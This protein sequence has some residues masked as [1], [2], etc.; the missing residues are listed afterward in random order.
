MTCVDC[1]GP[2]SSPRHK[3]CAACAKIRHVA[4]VARWQANNEER[5]RA[6][7]RDYYRSNKE[8]IA[9]RTKRWRSTNSDRERERKR[10]WHEKDPGLQSAYTRKSKYGISRE[11][12]AAILAAQ[13]GKCAICQASSPGA[14]G[15][16]WHVDHD[17]RF[18]SSDPT[19]HRGLLCKACNIGLGAFRDNIG[20]MED[21][22]DYLT[23]HQ[24]HLARASRA[25]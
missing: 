22:I 20:V 6:W 24:L 9:E 3:V 25:A 5:M 23:A 14:R 2:K 21:A 15:Q 16:G 7:R 13:G 18:A 8:R 11:R 4:Q 17:H 10:R 1:G 19:G 12:F